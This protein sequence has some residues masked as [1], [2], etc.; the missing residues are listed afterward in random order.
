[1]FA[2]L[3]G[4]CLGFAG[5]LSFSQLPEFTQ[6]YAQRLGGHLDELRL[7]VDGFDRDAQSVGQSRS[8]ALE[9]LQANP[10]A[11]VTKRGD[12][13]AA[14]IDRY[15]HY[16]HVHAQLM[17][18]HSVQRIWVFA[19]SFDGDIA[20]AAWTRF[21]PAL[22]LTF[23]G[24]LHAGVGLVIGLVLSLGLS[25]GLARGFGWIGL[26]GGKKAARRRR[27]RLSSEP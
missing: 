20:Q 16:Q 6:Q 10:D 22:P 4:L 27:K 9:A 2:R 24:A 26:T 3:F 21:Q 12:S 5:A 7:F 18:A 11:F 17:E 14:T 15:E 19:T 13:A 1:M 8:Q 23:E 25:L